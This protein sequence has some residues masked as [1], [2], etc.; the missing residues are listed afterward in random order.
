MKAHPTRRILINDE[1]ISSVEMFSEATDDDNGENR[2]IFFVFI[3]QEKAKRVRRSENDTFIIAVGTIVF[4]AVL[5]GFLSTALQAEESTALTTFFLSRKIRM[6]RTGE[7]RRPRD[8]RD[9]LRCRYRRRSSRRT[10][11]SCL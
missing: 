9:D 8:V 3:D 10:R 1:L 11:S 6:K 5:G 2:R 4:R 7:L